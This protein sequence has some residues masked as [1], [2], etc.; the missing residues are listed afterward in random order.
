MTE[1]K[2]IQ[3]YKKLEFL[4]QTHRSLEHKI[5][6][7]AQEKPYDEFSVVRFKKEKLML[8]DKIMQLENQLYPDIIAWL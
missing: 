3:L 6:N 1:D 7:L 2:Y 8:R 4:R 5:T